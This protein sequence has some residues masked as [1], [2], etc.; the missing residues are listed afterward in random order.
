M[1]KSPQVSSPQKASSFYFL[2]KSVIM[3]RVELMTRKTT[4]VMIMMRTLP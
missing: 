1:E 2:A 3:T 4:V